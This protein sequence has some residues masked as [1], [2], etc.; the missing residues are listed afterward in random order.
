[1]IRAYMQ[2]ITVRNSVGRNRER[3]E[4]ERERAELVE[5]QNALMN[6]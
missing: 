4:S 3:G 2:I 6:T 1:M 5:R